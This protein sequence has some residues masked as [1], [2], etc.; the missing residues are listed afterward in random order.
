MRKEE[1]FAFAHRELH[2]LGFRCARSGGKLK[3]AHSRRED[4]RPAFRTD[5]HYAPTYQ[6]VMR[7][8]SLWRGLRRTSASH[9]AGPQTPSGYDSTFTLHTA[10]FAASKLV[11]LQAPELHAFAVSWIGRPV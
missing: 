5:H 1:V 11:R 6:N 2:Q 7:N 10:D 8:A 4:V 9:T 3:K